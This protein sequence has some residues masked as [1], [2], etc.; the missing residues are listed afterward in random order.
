MSCPKTPQSKG[1]K[2]MEEKQ[3]FQ[4]NAFGVLESDD[5]EEEVDISQTVCED[6]DRPRTTTTT[7]PRTKARKIKRPRRSTE[8]YRIEM[9]KETLSSTHIRPLGPSTSMELHCTFFGRCYACRHLGHSQKWCALRYCRI[10]NSFGHAEQV[11]TA[12]RDQKE[13]RMPR[14]AKDIMRCEE[15]VVQRNPPAAREYFS[16]RDA[17]AGPPPQN[18]DAAP[19]ASASLIA[20]PCPAPST[21]MITN[22]LINHGFSLDSL[23]TPIDL[24]LPPPLPTT[25]I[26]N[27][28]LEPPRLPKR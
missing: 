28:R 3:P 2:T 26:G 15:C 18:T 11:C 6:K 17:A 19:S 10:C 16:Y 5:D 1:K 14:Q 7:P 24:P 8:S 9:G 13:K 25:T 4:K 22:S 23:P 21:T 27:P 12:K 20:Q